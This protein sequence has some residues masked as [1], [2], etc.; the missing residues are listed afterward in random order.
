MV[1]D[2]INKFPAEDRLFKMDF[3]HFPEIQDTGETISSVTSVTASPSGLTVGA[4]VVLSGGKA[5]TVRL[6]G[7]TAGVIYKVQGLALTNSGNTLA[8][9]GNINMVSPT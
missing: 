7:G 4:T 6:S 5:I 1:I 2:S 3:Q 9:V 8:I